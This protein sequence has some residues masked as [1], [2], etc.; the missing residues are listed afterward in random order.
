MINVQDFS[1]LRMGLWGMTTRDSKKNRFAYS[2][3]LSDI[4]EVKEIL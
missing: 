3:G 2:I 4:G 1:W